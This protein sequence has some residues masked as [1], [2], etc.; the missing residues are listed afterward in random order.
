MN[1]NNYFDKIYLLNLHKRKDR[2]NKSI[3]KLNQVGLEYEVFS[4]VDGSV[5]QSIWSK[6]DIPYFSNSSYLGCA[7]S[8]L[9][10]Y[11]DALHNGYEKIL[12]IEDDN[13]I[14]NEIM[15]IFD[16]LVI[17]EWSDL[18]YLG[19]IP[20]NDDCSM[21]DY[22]FGIQGHN[23]IC[24]KIFKPTNLWGLFAYGIKSEL[25]KEMVDLYNQEFPMEIDRY[26]VNDIQ[27]R[28]NSIAISPQLFCCDDNVHS[29]NLGFT[30][31]NMTQKSIDSRFANPSDYI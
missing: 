21:W 8:H 16:S 13:L 19:Y 6:L 26:F 1:I 2:L 10:I 15:K 9:S 4:G 29:D 22:T 7:I 5:M 23:F 14:H 30:P 20:L 31:P 17:P 24:H 11:Q 3:S 18:F 28:G 27:K 25:M 12:I